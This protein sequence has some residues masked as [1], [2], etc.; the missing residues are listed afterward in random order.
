MQFNTSMDVEQ[1]AVVKMTVYL[2]IELDTEIRV[3]AARGR[4]TISAIA[5]AAF[6]SYLEQHQQTVKVTPIAS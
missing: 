1:P 5:A 3:A 4:T 6:A 2:P